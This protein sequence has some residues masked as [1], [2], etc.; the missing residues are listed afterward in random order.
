MAHLASVKL[1]TLKLGFGRDLSITHAGT[2]PRT[3]LVY[4]LTLEYTL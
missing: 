2:L 3:G 4:P 1:G